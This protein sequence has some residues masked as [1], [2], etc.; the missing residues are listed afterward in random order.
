MVL[1]VRCEKEHAVLSNQLTDGFCIQFNND[2]IINHHGIEYYDYSAHIVYLKYADTIWHQAFNGI[3]FTVYADFEEIYHGDSLPSF[4][5]SIM[6]GPTINYSYPD[7]VI[8]IGNVFVYDS[9][10]QTPPDPREDERIVATLAKYDQFHCG[11][12]CTIDTVIPTL[13]GLTLKFTIVN[14]DS[15]NYYI[16]SP[17]KMGMGLFH[18]F[19]NGLRISDD[20]NHKSY[21]HHIETLQP[22]PFDSWNKEWFDLIRPDGKKSFTL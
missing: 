5:C 13:S 12:K 3:A 8:S 4:S 1:F 9:T 21:G 20:V 19:T 16:L 7:F 22:D 17:D 11:L 10:G 15:F 14:D 18:Y 2:R 6:P